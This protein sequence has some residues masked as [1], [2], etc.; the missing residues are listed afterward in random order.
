MVTLRTTLRNA[1]P[2]TLLS[3]YLSDHLAGATGGIE[4]A[5]RALDNNRGS[6]FE[7]FL[8]ELLKEVLQDRRALE[9]LMRHLDVEASPL[10]RAAAVSVERI[11]RL[12][13]NGQLVGY[14]PLSRLVELEGLAAGVETKLNLWRS[15]REVLPPEALPAGIDLGTLI[16]RAE[17]QR[18]TI[19][20]HRLRAAGNALSG[21]VSPR[22]PRVSG[23]SSQMDPEDTR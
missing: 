2:S 4:L 10:K 23:E 12:K 1:A 3:V 22:A 20:R 8:Q 9:R 16:E 5:R 18:K 15:L 13:L 11:G 14:S 7:P 21:A 19:E 17:R 6:E